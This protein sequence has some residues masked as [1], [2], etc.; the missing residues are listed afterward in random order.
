MAGDI[1]L[2]IDKGRI[3][4]YEKDIL[5]AGICDYMFPMRFVSCAKKEQVTYDCAGYCPLS[6]MQDLDI[7]ELLGIMEKVFTILSKTG[8][9]FIPPARI[10]LNEDTVFYDRKRDRVRIAY[11]P[12]AGRPCSIKAGAGA[13]IKMMREKAPAE[14]KKY[15]RRAQEALQLYNYGPADIA[16]MLAGMKRELFICGS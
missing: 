6:R 12:T 10:M 16:D 5:T 11:V 1:K 8:D 4:E 3:R 15:F 2:L 13:F 9:H 14:T 7:R